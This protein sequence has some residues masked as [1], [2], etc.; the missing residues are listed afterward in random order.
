MIGSIFLWAQR[1]YIVHRFLIMIPTLI[2]ISVLVFIIIELPPGDYLESYIAELESMGES[3]D[4]NKIAFLRHEYGFD[5]P[6][7]ERYFHWVFGMLQGDF[8]FS[9]EHQVPVSEVVGDSLYLTIVVSFAT[10]IFTWLVAFPIGI[11]SAT[12]QYSWGDY[13]LTFIGLMGLATPNFLLALVMLYFANVIFGTSIG[14]LMDPEYLDQ[15]WSIDKAL[16]VLEHL[17]IP[18]VVIGTSG[19]AGMIRRLRANLLDELEKQYVVTGRAKGLAPTRL[20]LKYPLRMALNF[21]ISDI[22]SLLPGIVSGAELVAMVLS[23]PTTGPILIAALQSQDMYLAG[24]VP[25]VPVGADRGRGVDLGL[26]AGGARPAHPAARGNDAMTAPADPGTGQ[27]GADLAHFVSSEP[28]DPESILALTPEQ[29]RYYLASQWRLMWWKLK[30]HRLA[31]WSGLFLLVVY[32]SILISEFLAPYG[33][34]S[35]HRYSIYAPPQALHLFHEGRFVGPFVYGRDYRLNRETLQREHIENRNKIYKLRFFCAGDEYFFWGLVRGNVHLVCPAE[36]GTLFLLGTDRLGRDVLSRIIYGARISMTIGL[37]GITISFV[38]GMIIGGLA[39][40]YGGGPRPDR[41]ASHRGHPVVPAD[42]IVDG[43][44]GDPARHLEPAGHLFR[45]HRHPGVA[46]LDRS[47]QGR[48][49]QAVVAAR[50]GLLHRGPAHGG[51]GAAHHRAPPDAGLYEPSDRHG[52]AEHSDHGPRRD[53]AQLPRPRSQ[54][55]DHELGR[56][57][58]RGSEHQRGGALP[59]AHTA[60]G[61]GDPDHPRLQLLRRRAARRRRPVQVGDAA[62]PPGQ[63]RAPGTRTMNCL[64]A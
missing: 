19:T 44:V 14:G 48:A 47:G 9:F 39:G 29:E 51:A 28:F 56:A 23:L 52:D 40:Y 37:V 1:S 33:L 22:G 13:G 30:R 64:L 49:L 34:H 41:S 20:V 6:V 12:H 35:R 3:V 17:W 54:A 42:P 62:V 36:N 2:A 10:V 25:H 5:L 4:P 59:M 16:S 27:M 55:A 57:A 60:G 43:A 8:G 31:V 61:A 18:V 15:P 26:R 32:A 53:G 46:R 50:G 7:H 11:Y 58:Q 45:H 24:I 21:F 38:L 63:P